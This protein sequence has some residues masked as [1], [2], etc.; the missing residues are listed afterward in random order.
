MARKA[1]IEKEKKRAHLS[2]LKKE[3]RAELKKIIKSLETSPEEKAEAV[4][5][6]NKLPKNSSAI[7]MR[8][9]CLLTGRPR[10]NYRKFRMSRLCFREMASQAMIPGVVKSSW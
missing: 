9:R 1:L 7:R 6:L 4:R 10:G 8:N 5:K 2:A 3:K